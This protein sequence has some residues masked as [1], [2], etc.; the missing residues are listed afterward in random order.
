MQMSII[1]VFPFISSLWF[2]SFIIIVIWYFILG[3]ILFNFLA[4]NI[5]SGAILV[6]ILSF[7]RDLT[8]HGFFIA[9][10]FKLEHLEGGFLE[11]LL[12]ESLPSESPDEA[13]D[14]DYDGEELR[15]ENLFC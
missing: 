11:E 8:P 4:R 7:V 9:I 1:V 3:R 6:W 10:I 14:D 13:L 12:S 2:V 5:S 15:F